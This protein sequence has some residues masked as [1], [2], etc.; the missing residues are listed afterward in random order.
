[1][2]IKRNFIIK[3]C[4]AAV[5][6]WLS[7]LLLPPC[8]PINAQHIDVFNIPREEATD[9]KTEGAPELVEVEV[10]DSYTYKVMVRKER[11]DEGNVFARELDIKALADDEKPPY[12]WGQVEYYDRRDIIQSL[13]RT[14]GFIECTK[15]RSGVLY[16][17]PDGKK[18]VD[19]GRWSMWDCR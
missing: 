2:I 14:T 6:L 15:T 3:L 7:T 5:A 13:T 17:L 12:H 4:C 16:F 18:V 1:M 19:W 8:N 10:T 11:L 9:K